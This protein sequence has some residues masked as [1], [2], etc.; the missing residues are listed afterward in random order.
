MNMFHKLFYND[1]SVGYAIIC[2]YSHLCKP[3]VWVMIYI[4][5]M[6]T[7]AN[8][9]INYIVCR[10][11]NSRTLIE[12]DRSMSIVSRPLSVVSG[13]RMWFHILFFFHSR[14]IKSVGL[15]PQP[16]TDNNR[17]TTSIEDQLDQGRSFGYVRFSPAMAGL[18]DVIRLISMDLRALN[19]KFLQSRLIL[20]LKSSC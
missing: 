17:R 4:L 14:D 13:I 3:G 20:I 5:F 19:L 8:Y 2:F 1:N 7:I 9:V 6:Q 12:R 16:T 18:Y 15:V 10:L 11:E